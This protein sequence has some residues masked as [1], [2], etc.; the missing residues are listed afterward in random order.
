MGPWR[1]LAAGTAL[2]FAGSI[3]NDAGIMYLV[4]ATLL[5]AAWW[6]RERPRGQRTLAVTG[7]AVAGLVLG[8]L[9]TLSYNALTMG[10]PLLPTQGMEVRDFLPATTPE[11]TTSGPRVAY[12][13]LWKGGT[14]SQVQ[15]GG[16]RLANFP[17]TAPLQWNFIRNAYG[18]TLLGIAALGIVTSLLFRPRLFLLAVPYSVAAFLLYSCWSRPDQRYII[19]IYT[20][21]PFLVT[22]GTFGVVDFVRAAA[23]RRGEAVARP[24]AI[25]IAVVAVL[26]AM[27]PIPLP[28]PI[29]DVLSKDVLATL[30]RAFPIAIAVGA[31][32]AATW[33]R[34]RITRYLAPAFAVP[35]VLFAMQRAD[36]AHGMRA[37]FQ[38]PQARAARENLRRLL[39]AKSVVITSEDMGRPAEN[40]EYYGGVPALY[41]TDLDRWRLKASQVSLSFI[42]GRVRP[43]LLVDPGVPERARV[44]ADLAANGFLAEKVATIPPARNLEHFV[45]APVRREV[46]S[47]L[48]RISHPALEAKMATLPVK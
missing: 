24:I 16:L 28:P 22:E 37:P 42:T 32:A 18:W 44:L 14:V 26:V 10:N 46:S 13:S 40:I 45:A 15:G 31:L 38:G 21:I 41:I 1:T 29:A 17:R 9:P 19:G 20:M 12:P 7:A 27:A 30:A 11:A 36:A 8:L 48:F 5:A 25:G 6:I 34:E 47:E 23:R 39:E 35:L 4:P 43:Y 33:P 2:G 3:R